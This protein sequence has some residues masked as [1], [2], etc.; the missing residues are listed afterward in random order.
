M[1]NRPLIC[2]SIVSVT[3]NDPIIHCGS[4]TPTSRALVGIVERLEVFHARIGANDV[5]AADAEDFVLGDRDRH[6]RLLGEVDAGGLQLLVEGDVR[7]ADDDRVDHVG[8]HQLHLVDDGVEL[9]AAQREILLADDLQFE[10]VFNVLAR[11]LV[12]GA[13]P[14]IVGAEQIE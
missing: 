13:W 1:T 11:D 4:S 9:R 6:Q 5:F 3:C 2:T 10:N 8:L 14:D 12:G 7:A